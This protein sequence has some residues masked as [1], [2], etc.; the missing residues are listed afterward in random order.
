M[1]TDPKISKGEKIHPPQPGLYAAQPLAHSIQEDGNAAN[2]TGPSGFRVSHWSISFLLFLN[3]SSLIKPTQFDCVVV[4][5]CKE[6][7]KLKKR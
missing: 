3:Y 1:A 6:G 5:G 2:E 4:I 7:K